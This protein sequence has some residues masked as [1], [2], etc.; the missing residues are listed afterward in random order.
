[1]QAMPFT[2]AD[3]R[4]GNR[5]TGAMFFTIFG[6]VWLIAWAS[7]VHAGAAWFAAIVVITALLFAAAWQRYRRDAPLAARFKDSPEQRRAKRN[8]NI[9]NA[10]QWTVISVL[11]QVL[12]HTGHGAWIIPMAIGIIGLHFFPLAALFRNPMH[13]LTGRAMV[14]LAILYPLLAG[15]ASPIG[16]LGAGIVLWLSAAWSLN[17]GRMADS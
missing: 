10:V 11:A 7:S 16:F 5:G 9:V 14:A 8:F 3:T 12:R 15:P 1:M 6:A 4:L 17:P 13:Y 2:K